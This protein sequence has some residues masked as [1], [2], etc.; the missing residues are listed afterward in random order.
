MCTRLVSGFLPIDPEKAPSAQFRI[1]VK[2]QHRHLYKKSTITCGYCPD[3]KGSKSVKTAMQLKCE[4]IMSP[5]NAFFITLTLNDENL[6]DDY[7]IHLPDMQKFIKRIRKELNKRYP[8]NKFRYLLQCEYGGKY[9]RPHYHIIVFDYPIPDLEPAESDNERDGFISE[10]LETTWGKGTIFI[11][12]LSYETCLYVV[13]HHYK[14]RILDKAPIHE[15]PV[16]H[17]VTGE[18]ITERAP[19]KTTRSARPAIG[20]SFFNQYLSDIYPHDYLIHADQKMPV[21]KRF[22]T[23]LERSNPTEF[24]KIKEIRKLAIELRT[25]QENETRERYILAK[26]KSLKK[27]GE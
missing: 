4:L 27:A 20:D 24:L 10:Y 15:L 23:L 7:S 6:R 1:Y 13:Q 22:D 9:S 17:P 8:C 2:P 5:D 11:M 14:D 12:P 19:E 25:D 26:I 16:T 21:P 3:C 18:Y